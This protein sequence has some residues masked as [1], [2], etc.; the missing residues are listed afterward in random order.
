MSYEVRRL[1][2]PFAACNL[3]IAEQC[4]EVMM[5]LSGPS[6]SFFLHESRN[7]EQRAKEILGRFPKTL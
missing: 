1:I 3:K 4:V 6:I 5:S 7:S 2:T